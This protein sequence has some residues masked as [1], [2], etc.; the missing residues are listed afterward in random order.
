MTVDL[1]SSWFIAPGCEDQVEA[2]LTQLAAAV[3]QD[4]PGTLTYLVHRPL[5]ATSGLQS[6]PPPPGEL[7]LFF[8]RYADVAAFQAHVNGPLFQGFVANYGQCFIGTG[9]KPFS[10]VQFLT[11]IAGFVER[12]GDTDDQRENDQSS[13]THLT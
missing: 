7:V 12:G 2:A 9:G 5:P 3:L 13:H 10:T 1:T 11:P 4:E 8:E 6:L